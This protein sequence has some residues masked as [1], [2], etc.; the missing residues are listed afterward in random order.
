MKIIDKDFCNSSIKFGELAGQ[1]LFGEDV[2]ANLAD[3]AI[4]QIYG[5][6]IE[7]LTS[8]EILIKQYHVDSAKILARALFEAS[9]SLLLLL[10][11]DD[12][13]AQKFAK[14]FVNYRELKDIQNT[15]ALLKEEK[16]IHGNS[17]IENQQVTALLNR[18]KDK[19]PVSSTDEL[20]A[21]SLTE[22]QQNFPHRTFVGK[23]KKTVPHWYEVKP[24]LSN[25][26]D[27][28]LYLEKNTE[29]SWAYKLNSDFVHGS[30]VFNTVWNNPT[31]ENIHSEIK[32]LNILVIHMITSVQ[33]SMIRYYNLT[34]A[35]FQSISL[36]VLSYV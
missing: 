11:D 9:L 13:T 30:Q 18:Y 23:Q 27:L 17:K 10:H 33:D 29:Y 7:E 1:V 31:S 12:A 28:S 21:N 32:I 4:F 5:T 14:A 6:L 2:H 8:I 26:R 35:E 25:L 15:L 3:I 24:Q 19:Y 34:E 36:F 16:T 22:Y 20:L